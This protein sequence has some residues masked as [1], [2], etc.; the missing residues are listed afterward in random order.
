[1]SRLNEMTEK[2]Y[3]KWFDSRSID[4][5]MFTAE[6]NRKAKQITRRLI[7]KVFSAQRIT[8]QELEQE[9]EQLL[10][11]AAEDKRYEEIRDTEPPY[12]IK[13]YLQVAMQIVGYHFPDLDIY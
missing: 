7:K 12:H 4:F 10:K 8:Q 3:L 9:A 5:E 13:N 1:M 2:E 6:G 11:E